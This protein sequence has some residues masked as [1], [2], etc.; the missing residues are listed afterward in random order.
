[1]QTFDLSYFLGKLFFGD[2]GFRN[3]FVYQPKLITLES[4]EDKGIE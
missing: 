3:M 2:D 4:K 1:M